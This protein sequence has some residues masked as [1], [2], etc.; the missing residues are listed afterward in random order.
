MGEEGREVATLL[1]LHS[2]RRR[3][4]FVVAAPAVEAQGYSE[5]VA[6]ASSRGIRTIDVCGFVHTTCNG[7]I[8]L[9]ICDSS[10]FVIT[11][12]VFTG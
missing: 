5:C 1:L 2:L 6:A 12:G 9:Q 7:S 11:P 8:E 4:T 10:S 3:L